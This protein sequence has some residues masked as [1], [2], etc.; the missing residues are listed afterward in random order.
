M[1]SF[2]YILWSWT[3]MWSLIIAWFMGYTFKGLSLHDSSLYLLTV[4]SGL[5]IC[6]TMIFHGDLEDN[7]IWTCTLISWIYEWLLSDYFIALFFGAFTLT[8][9]GIVYYF[10]KSYLD[11]Y[12]LY[13]CRCTF[14]WIFSVVVFQTMPV[15]MDS[16]S[17]SMVLTL[18]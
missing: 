2:E 10:K 17:W 6:V 16:W 15:A 7:L 4:M 5:L 12:Q 11:L 13:V 14:I 8:T 1:I 9:N 3:S 18:V